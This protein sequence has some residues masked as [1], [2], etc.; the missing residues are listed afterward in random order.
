MSTTGYPWIDGDILYAA[1]LNAA[2]VPATGGSMNG[3]LTVEGA[4]G[5]AGNANVSGIVYTTSIATSGN[6]NAYNYTGTSMQL[7]GNIAASGSGTFGQLGVTGNASVSGAMT[8]TG[9]TNVEGALGVAGNANV[10][11]IVYATSVS[12]SG[13][14]NAANYIGASMQ[15][16]GNMETPGTG[17]FGQLGVTG[18]AQVGGDL[19]VNGSLDANGGLLTVFRGAATNPFIYL[20]DGANNRSEFYFDTASGR[21]A[22]ADVSSSTFLFLDS[23]GNFTYVGTGATAYKPGGGSWTA[24][25]DARIKTVTGDYVSGLTEITALSP[26]RFVYKGND[27]DTAD[28]AS[29]HAGV[30]TEFVGLVAQEA[31]A[32]M[33]ELVTRRAGFIN[34]VP[35]NDLRSLDPSALVFALVNAVRE[36]A[37]RVAALEGGAP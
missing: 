24:T 9:S 29:P 14:I 19:V 8:V 11:G 27:T 18:F 13:N 16:V 15:L 6:I 5:V 22:I 31:E 35:V 7:V 28:G 4:L 2:F 36:L 10:S 37:D 23:D 34:R 17:T 12:T 26:V 32:V 25:S 3:N 20:N 1:D 33:P 30:V 21:T